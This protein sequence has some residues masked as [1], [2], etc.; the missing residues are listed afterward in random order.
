MDSA[1]RQ[2]VR[3]RGKDRCEYCQL[4]QKH[5]K[6]YRFHIEHIIPKKH[7]GI[8]DASNLALACY[9]CNLH[10]GSNLSGID[11]ETGSIVQLL[12]PRQQQ[13]DDHFVFDGS[14]IRGLT[15]T[16]RATV[17]VFAMNAPIR[18]ELRAELLENGE[19]A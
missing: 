11:P 5:D 18:L 7:R 3:E 15:P 1:T 6:F 14:A 2:L 13:W 17:I 16:G 4:H 9:H 19:V 12:N 8:D 10:K